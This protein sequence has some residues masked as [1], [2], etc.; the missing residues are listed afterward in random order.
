MS[1]GYVVQLSKNSAPTQTRNQ[2]RF[3][4]LDDAIYVRTIFGSMLVFAIF[5]WSQILSSDIAGKRF[6]DNETL[7]PDVIEKAIN[8]W[9]SPELIEKI[10]F[11]VSQAD[12]ECRYVPSLADRLIQA[13]DRSASGWY[14]KAVCSNLNKEFD[15]ALE[16]V[17]KSLSFDPINPVFLVAQGKLAIAAGNK[18]VGIQALDILKKQYPENPEIPLLESSLSVL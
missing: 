3:S 7:N 4:I 18:A 17:G 2:S 13:D 6:L 1:A 11:A 16:Y 14:F 12:S 15:I 9:T 10:S 8:N 5:F